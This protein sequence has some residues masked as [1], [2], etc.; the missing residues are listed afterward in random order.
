MVAPTSYRITRFGPADGA[1]AYRPAIAVYAAID[2]QAKPPT[3]TSQYVVKATLQP[4]VPPYVRRELR[5]KL[6]AY[7]QSPVIQF[8]T[9]VSSVPNYQWLV[10]APVPCTST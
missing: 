4:D 5:A 3:P 1:S 2:L 7:A 10:G 9:E 8:P 6:E